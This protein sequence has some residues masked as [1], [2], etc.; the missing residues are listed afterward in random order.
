MVK[1]VITSM[2]EKI[3]SMSSLGR[4]TGGVP[5]VQNERSIVEFR[6]AASVDICRNGHKKCF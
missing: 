5:E 4:I 3:A 2:L 6:L 1:Y